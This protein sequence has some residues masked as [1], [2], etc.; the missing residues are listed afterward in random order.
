MLATGNKGAIQ[1][2]NFAVSDCNGSANFD[3]LHMALLTQ[4]NITESLLETQVARQVVQSGVNP[5][6]ACFNKRRRRLLV[7]RGLYTQSH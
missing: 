7:Y 3:N 4:Y 5:G 6:S 1:A 2:T